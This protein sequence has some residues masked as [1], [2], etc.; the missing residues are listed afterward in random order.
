LVCCPDRC[1]VRR[2]DRLPLPYISTN[3]VVVGIGGLSLGGF[4][5]PKPT[6]CTDCQRCVMPD[7]G[8]VVCRRPLLAL[9]VVTHLVARILASRRPDGSLSRSSGPA[10]RPADVS[11]AGRL[12][13]STPQSG[14]QR[15]ECWQFIFWRVMGHGF[16]TC[17][18]T[19]KSPAGPPF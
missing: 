11:V 6:C 17:T 9:G 1:A 8:N 14:T 5:V 12:S 2:R 13:S 3:A 18:R 10:Y 4:L 16:A 19:Y 15:H 7:L